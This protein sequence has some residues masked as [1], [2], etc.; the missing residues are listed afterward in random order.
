MVASVLYNQKF[1][2]SLTDVWFVMN[3]YDSWVANKMI[4]GKQMTICRYADN[5]KASHVRPKAVDRIVEYLRRVYLKMGPV[6]R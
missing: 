2:K 1:T 6:Q 5:L 3:L 4:D